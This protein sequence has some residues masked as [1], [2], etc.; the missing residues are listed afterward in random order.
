MLAA[1]SIVL[2]ATRP[3][4]RL[5]PSIVPSS[6]RA[7]VDVATCHARELTRGQ[8]ALD[9]GAVG[10]QHATVQVGADAA[11]IL[12]GQGRNWTA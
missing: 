12:A 4:N 1:A 5:G 3:L 2:A 8:Q 9:G 6:P 10:A 11:E 7:A